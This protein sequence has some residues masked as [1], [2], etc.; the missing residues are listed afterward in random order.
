VELFFLI[1]G[2]VLAIPSRHNT[3]WAFIVSRIVRLYPTYWACLGLT[4]IAAFAIGDTL[5]PVNI[6]VN[7]TM[8]TAFFGEPY[9][10]GVYWSLT[11]EIAFYALVGVSGAYAARNN[12]MTLA[13]GM[14][15]LAGACSVAGWSIDEKSK[16]TM[17]LK[18]F[19]FF[20]GGIA[21][22]VIYRRWGRRDSR[23]SP[24]TLG[25]AFLV[26]VIAPV[27]TMGFSYSFHLL[28]EWVRYEPLAIGVIFCSF[29]LAVVAA[30]WEARW[31][32]ADL[33]PGL[34]KR[35]MS[36]VLFAT[37]GFGACTY[38]FYLLHHRFGKAVMTLWPS[39]GPCFAA[40]VVAILSVVIHEV[41]EV[42]GVRRLRAWFGV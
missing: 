11:E 15:V 20:A 16:L 26:M 40:I 6:V 9:I 30:C 2:F 42:R 32:R 38:P 29:A 35:L 12:P 18:Y 37:A 17:V 7:T 25:T 1:S 34:V 23:L 19:P 27:V 28:A 5:S 41:V 14:V 10:D 24:V 3:M 21:A 33:S 8:L 13:I 39:G 22:S 4:C 31:G 36:Q